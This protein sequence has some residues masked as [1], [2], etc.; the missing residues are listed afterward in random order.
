MPELNL[1]IVVKHSFTLIRECEGM[2]VCGG[3]P[4]C[5]VKLRLTAS[6]GAGVP[7]GLGAELVSIRESRDSCRPPSSRGRAPTLAGRVPLSSECG[8]AQRGACPCHLGAFFLA[9]IIY[10][11]AV[12]HELGA[13]NTIRP[14]ILR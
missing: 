5:P 14:N 6:G 10:L 13:Q 12:L 3:S 4:L 1:Q 8:L 11:L 9:W 2:F 7:L